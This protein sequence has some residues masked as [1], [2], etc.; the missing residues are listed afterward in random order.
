VRSSTLSDRAGTNVY[1]KLELF[2]KTGS[3]KPRGA[4][5]QLR[6]LM[7]ETGA[8]RFV[9]VSGGNFAQGLA[10]AG[11]VLGVSTTIVMPDTTPDNYVQAT[12]GYGGMVEFVESIA[13]A[14]DR[15]DELAAA[16]ATAAHPFDHPAMMAGDGTLGLELVEDVPELTDAFISVGGGGLITGV[17]SAVR[18]LRPTARIWAVETDGAQVLHDSLAAGRALSMTPTSLARTLGSPYLSEVAYD[19]A[20]QHVHES[21]VVSDAMAYAAV[22]F[23]LERAKV[24]PEL[25]AA[26]TLA[27]FEGVAERFGPA[28]H[29]VLVLCGGNV[30]VADLVDYRQRFDQ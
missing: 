22:V 4:F 13:A 12:R 5:N 6:V 8:E 10:Y 21:L 15:A 23:L 27:A 7:D 2:Q 28:D 20:R 26:C 29:V 1:L 18:A 3:F 16:G 25:A 17:G 11:S 9:G 14:M 24:L 19:F 30:S